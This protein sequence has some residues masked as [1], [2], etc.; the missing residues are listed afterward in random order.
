MM[1]FN[2]M[3]AFASLQSVHLFWDKFWKEQLSEFG[4]DME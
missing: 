1:K 3:G 2:E 4:F